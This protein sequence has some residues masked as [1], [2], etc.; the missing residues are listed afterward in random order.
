[1]LLNVSTCL[2]AYPIYAIYA[3]YPEWYVLAFLATSVLMGFSAGVIP[4]VI[5]ELFPTKI[6]FSGIAV[7]YNL[8]FAIFGGLTPFI[9]LSLVYYT[10][11]KTAPAIYLGGVAF[12]A[13]LASLY[14][15]KYALYFVKRLDP[16]V[17]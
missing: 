13:L 5:S 1:L 8:G 9:S 10:G 6:R 16:V 7:S 12:L 17:S 15:S 14:V 11:L 2:M 3:Y 4:V